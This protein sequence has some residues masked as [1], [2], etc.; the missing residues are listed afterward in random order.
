MEAQDTTNEATKDEA[1]KDGPTEAD[2][3]RAALTS[4]YAAVET[5]RGDLDRARRD[6][7]WYRDENRRLSVEIGRLRDQAALVE[8]LG[9]DNDRL[10]DELA[11]RVRVD[12]AFEGARRCAEQLAAELGHDE[13]DVEPYVVV[14]YEPSAGGA[15]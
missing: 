14:P 6:L 11:E 15:S 4:A 2:F 12:A 9:R 3:L 7:A 10:R 13:D 1:T 5:W 8:A